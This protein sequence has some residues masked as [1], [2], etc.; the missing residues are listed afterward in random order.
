[1]ARSYIKKGA[2]GDPIY[3][4]EAVKG[5]FNVVVFNPKIT[6]G[7]QTIGPVCDEAALA[8]LLGVVMKRIP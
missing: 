1:M 7:G 2:S 8:K 5:Q 3:T 6:V 4:V